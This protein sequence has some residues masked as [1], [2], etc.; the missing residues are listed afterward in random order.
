MSKNE[1]A[2]CEFRFGMMMGC[3]QTEV[4]SE[5]YFHLS[6]AKGVFG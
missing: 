3:H 5:T 2:S 1:T 4:V 6:M